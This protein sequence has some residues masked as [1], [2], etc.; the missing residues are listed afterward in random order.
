MGFNLGRGLKGAAGLLAATGAKEYMME[1][2]NDLAVQRAEMLEAMREQKILR[3][4]D[5]AGEVYSNATKGP[6]VAEG[7]PTEDGAMPKGPKSERES[8]SSA[9]DAYYSKGMTDYGR[10]MDERL[11]RLDANDARKDQMAILDMRYNE[12]RDLRREQLEET[13]RYHDAQ[14][15]RLGQLGAGGGGGGRGGFE[16]LPEATKLR[17]IELQKEKARID[18]YIGDVEKANIE[19]KLDKATYAAHI[20]RYGSMKADI[21]MRI[22]D[23]LGDGKGGGSA[24]PSI[25]GGPAEKKDSGLIASP[26][27]TDPPKPKASHQAKDPVKQSEDLYPRGT[28]VIDGKAYDEFIDRRTGEIKRFQNGIGSDSMSMVRRILGN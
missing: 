18:G 1:K 11:A 9:R 12:D 15:K 13:K 16:K 20:K 6:G 28:V 3:E 19:G 10:L 14:I 21:D 2:E 22:D 7:P 26:V 8:V 25:L 4:R 24:M 17:I 27:A 5:R 23:L